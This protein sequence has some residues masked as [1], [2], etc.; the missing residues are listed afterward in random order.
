MKSP[1]T[2]PPSRFPRDVPSVFSLIFLFFTL[3]TACK[4]DNGKCKFGDPVAI[5]SDTMQAVKNHH[6]EI[7]DKTGI[8]YVVLKNGLL[9]EIEQSGCNTI[10][11]Q[12]TFEI[13]GDFSK[14]NDD[15]WKTLAAK[16]FQ[17]L[18]NAS[19]KLQPF[20]AWSEAIESVKSKLKLAEAIEIQNKMHVRL[21]KI[22]SADRAML[23]V[24]LSQE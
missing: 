2:F 15:F 7:K 16:N 19:V 11:Q 17:L 5:F 8:E 14:Q 21:D 20:I 10:N 18:S 9:L 6:F 13:M 3:F 4:T 23:V 1:L 22:V 12:F 24:Q